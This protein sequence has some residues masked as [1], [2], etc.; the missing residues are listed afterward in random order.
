MKFFIF[1][2]EDIVGGKMLNSDE[3]I[4]CTIVNRNELL[5]LNNLNQ[6]T[7]F[8]KTYLGNRAVVQVNRKQRANIYNA[9]YDKE[10]API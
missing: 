6:T 8:S 2:A 7:C 5:M 4:I 3:L 1:Y 10:K 9:S